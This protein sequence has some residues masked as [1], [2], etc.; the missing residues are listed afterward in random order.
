MS[1]VLLSQA[2]SVL[3]SP[4]QTVKILQR[5]VRALLVTS[6]LEIR[7]PLLQILESFSTDVLCCSTL[8]QAEEVLARQSFEVVFCDEHLTDGSYSSLIHANHFENR[9]PR[10]IVATRVGE[11]ELYLEALRKGAFDVVRSPWY[12]TDVE[13]T[14]IRALREEDS[15]SRSV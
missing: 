8:A 3:S 1:S 14:V 9:I 15:F 10:V 4:P 6:R 7:K 12:A 2:A 5:Y 11:W 13:M